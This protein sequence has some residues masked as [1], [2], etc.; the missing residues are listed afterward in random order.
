MA[1]RTRRFLCDVMLGKLAVYLRM[2]GYDT[3]NAGDLEETDDEAIRAHA[4]SE[5]PV[6][7]SRDRPLTDR[8][9]GAIYVA[10]HDVEEQLDELRAADIPLSLPD[11]PI[12]CGR[13]NGALTETPERGELPPYAPDD[14][15]DCYRCRDCGQL[16][17]RGSHWDRVAE[18]L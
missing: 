1:E 11:R 3:V 4:R 15:R 2:C 12:R 5:N 16:F 14:G 18:V 17:W 13:C 9:A 7:L 6:L 8:T 10:S